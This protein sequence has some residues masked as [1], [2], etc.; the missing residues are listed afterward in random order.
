MPDITVTGKEVEELLIKAW[1]EFKKDYDGK[2]REYSKSESVCSRRQAKQEHW[3]LWNESDLMAKLG[4][5]F[6]QELAASSLSGIEMHFDKN[7]NQSNFSKYTFVNK[8]EK[9][10]GRVDLII[11]Q[12][13]SNRPFLLCAEAKC[14]HCSEESISRGQRTASDAIKNDIERLVTIRDLGITEAVVFIMIDDYYYLQ[15]NPERYKEIKNVLGK[16]RKEHGL[17][18]LE[19]NSEVKMERWE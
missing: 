16:A 13:A 14:F 6:Y 11:A 19:H 5:Y 3:V 9:S 10:F 18:V 15:K 8:L 4:R 17:T 7:L 12:E 2:V 1:G